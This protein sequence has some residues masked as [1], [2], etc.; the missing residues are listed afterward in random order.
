MDPHNRTT[1]EGGIESPVNGVHAV[2]VCHC[3]RGTIDGSI[4]LLCSGRNSFLCL[5]T[6]IRQYPAFHKPQNPLPLSS[7]EKV[8]KKLFHNSQDQEHYC[9]RNDAFISSSSPSFHSFFFPDFHGFRLPSR[10]FSFSCKNPGHTFACTSIRKNHCP[11]HKRMSVISDASC[12]SAHLFPWAGEVSLVFPRWVSSLLF[13]QTSHRE[14][15][16]S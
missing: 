10:S 13:H 4:V 11:I 7:C 2:W 8:E 16:S 6:E 5:W 12:I 15:G 3:R 9:N 1:G 14:A